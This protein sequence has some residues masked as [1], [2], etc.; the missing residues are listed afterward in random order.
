[1]KASLFVT[2]YEMPR[3]LALVCAG[4]ARQSARGEFEVLF[5]DDG[6]GPETKL[7]IDE[8]IARS[9]IPARHLRQ[10][11]EGFRKCRILNQAARQARGEIFVFLDGDCV[12]HRHYIRD[13]LAS[14][15]D[16]RFLAGRRV[17]LGP[18]ISRWLTPEAVRGGFFDWPRPRLL[19]SDSEALNRTLR[20]SWTPLRRLLK[21]D[22]VADLKGCNYSIPRKALEAIN[23]FDE[24]Y[25]G[26]GREDTDVELRLRNLGLR[27]KSL[28][29]LALQ[30]HVWHPRR[31]FTPAN[32]DR[33]EELKR[34]GRVRCERG[35][36]QEGIR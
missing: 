16:G 32:D 7:V 18:L 17:E 24:Q 21:L 8:F 9:G 13:H 12:P 25:E 31:D 34:S 36:A 27:I 10:E 15:E 14:Q 5:C 29:G 28:K 1:M 3:H 22:R 4:L 19:L 26:Y 11:H 23:G 30:Y 33:L 35:L 20:V 6:S 2:T